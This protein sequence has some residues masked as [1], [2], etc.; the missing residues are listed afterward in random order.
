L[1]T[2]ARYRPDPQ[3]PRL[4]A[5][6]F[7]V[8]APAR[9]PQETLRFRNQRWAERIG[10]GALTAEEWTAHFARFEPLSGNLPAPLALRY[11]GHQF[12]T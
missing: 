2:D 4:G 10:L 11:H 3:T 6:L 7:D 1:P 8:V 5:E 9:F 12:R